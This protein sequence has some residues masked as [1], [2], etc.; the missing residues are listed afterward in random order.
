MDID[1][2]VANQMLDVNHI[3]KNG[4]LSKKLENKKRKISSREEN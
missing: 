3:P 2:H 4:K 1:V